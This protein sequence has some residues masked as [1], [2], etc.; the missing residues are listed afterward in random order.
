ML[1]AENLVCKPWGYKTLRLAILRMLFLTY[2][3]LEKRMN[4]GQSFVKSLHVCTYTV[5]K[6]CHIISAC[7]QECNLISLI[8]VVYWVASFLLLFS[9]LKF[10]LRQSVVIYWGPWS[11]LHGKDVS[12]PF[13]ILSPLLL[14]LESDIS[15]SLRFQIATAP[16]NS[17]SPANLWNHETDFSIYLGPKLFTN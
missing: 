11:S 9:F 1:G 8:G 5:L 13:R 6:Y 17:W 3:Q 10:L 2:L 14:Y 7:F 16:V 12:P 4:T 15:V